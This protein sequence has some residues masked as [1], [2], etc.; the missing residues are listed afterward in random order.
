M[1]TNRLL[2]AMMELARSLG[3]DVRHVDSCT[4]RGGALVHLKGREVLF[5]DA[6]ADPTEQLQ[7]AARALAGRPEL[8]DRFLLP[9]IRSALEQAAPET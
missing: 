8:E 6:S 5:L 9:E 1:E 2:E 3:I 4:E 7:A